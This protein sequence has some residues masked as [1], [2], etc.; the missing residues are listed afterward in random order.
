MHHSSRHLLLSALTVATLVAAGCSSDPPSATAVDPPTSPLTTDSPTT[1]AAP[2]TSSTVG[3]TTTEPTADAQIV[4]GMFDVGGHELH[5]RCAGTGSPTIVYLH[6]AIW[7]RGPQP[8]TTAR[9]LEERL[10]DT[11]KF[12]AY[13]RRN[14]G[15]SGEVDAPQRPDDVVADLY[16]LLDAVGAEPPYVLLGASFGGLIAN[17]VANTH[18]DDVVGMVLLDSMFPDELALDIH[19]P[20]EERYETLD[21]EDETDTQE[22]I[23]HFRMISTAA[24]FIGREP[25]IPVIY[26]ASEQEPVN[27]QGIPE[28]DEQVIGLLEAY[29]G[30]FAPG[31]LVWIDSPHFMEPAIPDE[32]AEAVRTVVVRAG[33]S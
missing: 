13:D 19:F 5:A 21:E 2:T 29:I 8:V 10:S 24:S 7:D 23:S 27:T 15:K 9:R 25:A 22:R 3:A 18:P 20:I 17:V 16:A 12:C 4:E 32:I 30:R 11:Y 28:Y 14:V 26:F 6:G 33:G 31:E 1:S